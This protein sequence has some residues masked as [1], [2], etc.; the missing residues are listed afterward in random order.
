M[1]GSLSVKVRFRGKQRER[2]KKPVGG[3]KYIDHACMHV[4]GGAGIP[5][6]LQLTQTQKKHSSMA[7]TQSW[8]SCAGTTS[9]G[10]FSCAR[11]PPKYRPLA[12]SQE[13]IWD[14]IISAQ[15][16]PSSGTCCQRSVHQTGA[17]CHLSLRWTDF[18]FGDDGRNTFPPNQISFSR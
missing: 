7:N 17:P 3:V 12:R 1:C 14:S 15:S 13:G 16:N 11:I 10:F 5:L 9:L 6:E 8:D 4:W 18:H 2:K